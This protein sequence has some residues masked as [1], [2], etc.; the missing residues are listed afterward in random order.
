MSDL[1]VRSISN[2]VSAKEPGFFKRLFWLFVSP[3]KLMTELA[4]KP[5]II[6]WLFA[7]PIA[8]ALPYIVRWSLYLDM[9][10]RQ[11]AA[12]DDYMESL[13]GVEMTPELIEQS[14]SQG[15]SVG[16][17]SIISEMFISSLLMALIFF[18]VFK[19]FGGKGKFKAYLS[20]IVHSNI[21]I[22]FYSLIL[23][24]VSYLTESLHENVALT[25]MATLVSP[26][27]VGP[28]LFGLLANIDIFRIWRYGVMAIGFTSVSNLK[29]RYV[30]IVTAV[31]LVIGIIVGTINVGV[32][33]KLM[34]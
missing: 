31:I 7:A 16:I 28:Y 10:R 3:G 1:Q 15:S 6:F 11:M 33:M 5:R 25:C 23:L 13:F 2:E 19:L 32:A 17:V 30:Y 9:L 34:G 8:F 29:K 22:A 18:G 20:V 24:A 21:I 4:Q 14:V 27:E 26:D 12:S